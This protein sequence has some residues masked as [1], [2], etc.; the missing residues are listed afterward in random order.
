M[1]GYLELDPA[2]HRC[3]PIATA[4]CSVEALLGQAKVA[5]VYA[6]RQLRMPRFHP[7][8]RPAELAHRPDLGYLGLVGTVIRGR[9]KTIYEELARLHA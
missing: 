7:S 6:G 5:L 3:R 9:R 1:S 8:A 4:T 2:V